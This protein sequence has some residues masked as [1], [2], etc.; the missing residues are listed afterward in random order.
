MIDD[1]PILPAIMS[2]ELIP[3]PISSCG[4]PRSAQLLLSFAELPDHIHRRRHGVFRVIRV[5]NGSTE[6]SHDHIADKLIDRSRMPEHYLD[7]PGEVLIS[8]G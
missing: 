5:V 2:P 3:M 8:T 1:D 6:Q 7:H 4:N